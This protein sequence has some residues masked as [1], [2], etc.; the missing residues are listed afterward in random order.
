MSATGTPQSD[1]RNDRSPRGG[2]RA[3]EFVRRA[4]ASPDSLSPSYSR[5]IGRVGA[6]AVALGVG[7]AIAAMPVA[8][9]DE[10]GSAG[11]SGASSSDTKTSTKAPARRQANRAAAGSAD[12]SSAAPSNSSS[13]PGAAASSGGVDRVG[14]GLASWLSTGSDSPAATRN[15]A[16]SSGTKFSSSTST[17]QLTSAATAAPIASASGFLG[18]FVGN[19]DEDSP[20]GGILLGNGYTWT[21]YGGVCTTGACNGGNGGLIGNGAQGG[22]KGNDRPG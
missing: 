5:Y 9:A 2:V 16:A 7:S 3:I 11:S 10:T 20:N 19:G 6:L 21:G 12:S 13:T 15:G 4:V 14:G 22:G 8:F 17:G 18:F 1:S